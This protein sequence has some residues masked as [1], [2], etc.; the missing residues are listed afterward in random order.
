MRHH[1]TNRKFGRV[2]S[3]RKAL[4]RSLALS[5]IKNDKIKTTEAKAKELRPLVEKLVTRAKKKSIFTKRLLIARL[6]S[7]NLDV[8][9]KLMIEI[10]KKYETRE[11]GYTR[12][13]KLG[14]RGG[15]GSDMA[16][17]EFV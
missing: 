12:I 15:D 2:S 17:I 11:G 10:A 6:G 8:I 16:Q 5:L 7:S 13:T 9:E 3:Q 4:L 1:N 14:F